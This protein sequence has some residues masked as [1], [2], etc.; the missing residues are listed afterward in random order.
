M[1]ISNQDCLKI[2]KFYKMKIPKTKHKL[3]IKAARIMKSNLCRRVTK[4]NTCYQSKQKTRK[5]NK[6]FNHL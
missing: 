1:L 5:K 6:Y 2:L 3:K 4:N